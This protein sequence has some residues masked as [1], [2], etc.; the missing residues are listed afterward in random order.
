MTE[1]V[2]SADGT[3]I[4][5]DRLG[6][7]AHAIIL[8]GSA[9]NYRAFDPTTAHIA[10]L[11][12]DQGF[13]VINYDRR[14]RGESE[15]TLPYAVEREVDDI[16]ALFDVLGGPAALYGNSSGG[17]LALW[18]AATPGVGERITKLALF[19][20]PL[21]LE[22]EGDDGLELRTIDDLVESGDR[23]AVV[24]YFMRNMP[25]Q[26]L[27]GAKSSPAWPDM[28]AIAHTLA[29]DVAV[30]DKANQAPWA[31]QWASVTQPVIAMV[32]AETQPI[33]P[34]AAAALAEALPGARSVE[35][36]AANH[37]VRPEVMAAI[38]GGFISGHEELATFPEYPDEPE[39][40]V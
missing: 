31:E 29:Y 17:A 30:L 22:G 27:E 16:A 23:G 37:G 1:F 11:L 19:E 20:V 38:L 9:M 24:E 21:T 7:G 10:A 34:P 25:P 8:V 15:D 18:A 14:G 36:D 6:S 35:I 28:L 5:Y 12:A 32:G 2:T 4:A 13:S 33:F 40:Q 3:R 39:Q 26:W